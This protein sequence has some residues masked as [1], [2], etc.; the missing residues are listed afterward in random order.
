MKK[1]FYFI[2]LISLMSLMI[3]SIFTSIIWGIILDPKSIPTEAIIIIIIM[4]FFET[5]LS[6]SVE[7]AMGYSDGKENNNSDEE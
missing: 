7:Y 2:L 5:I 4:S 1:N 6:I 3:F